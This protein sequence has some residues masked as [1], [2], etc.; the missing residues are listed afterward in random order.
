MMA[1]LAAGT[2]GAVKQDEAAALEVR[3]GELETQMAEVQQYLQDQSTAAAAMKL[4]MD[5]CETEGFTFGI[6]PESRHILLQGMRAFA[7]SAQTSVPGKE[8]AKP[9]K[10]TEP[11][12]LTEPAPKGK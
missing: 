1:A 2:F 12:K 7:T 6:N 9:A 5:V 10:R 3:V 8:T 11:A 4:A